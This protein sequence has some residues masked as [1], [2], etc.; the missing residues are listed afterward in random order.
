M[1]G[2]SV[3]P[4]GAWLSAVG[5]LR[6]LSRADPAAALHW[7]DATP[8]LS[9]ARTAPLR[10][11]ADRVPITPVI[12]PWQSGGGWGAKDKRS[13]DRLATLRSSVI[14]ESS[15]LNPLRRAI[16]AADAVIARH[17]SL[18][19]DELARILRNHLPDEALPWLDVAV[20][21]RSEPG[22]PGTLTVAWAPL[23]GTGGN[24]GRWDL[25][26]NYHAAI[27]ALALDEEPHPDISA[28]VRRAERRRGVLDDL[29][30]GT[31]YEPLAELSSGPYWP[32]ATVSG[33]ANPWA[34]ILTAEGLCAFGDQRMPEYGQRTQGWTASAGPEMGEEHAWG[35]AWLPMW[36]EPMTVP[37]VR[38]ILAGPWP[39]WRGRPAVRPADMYAALRARGWPPGV[40]GFARYGLAR[41][42]G[43]S[44]VA[45]P[46]DM[47]TPE[48]I[49]P[50]APLD[51]GLAAA[52]AGVAER[53]WT[54][55]VARKQ[56]PP[57]DAR[58]LRSGRPG[59]LPS[60]VDAWRAMRPGQGTRNDLS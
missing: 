5:A 51:A 13:A 21:L 31:E 3:G 28:S 20:P 38:V 48:R 59:W 8:V 43:R 11:I 26:A 27:L 4:M 10:D 42:H 22:A 23:A 56:A 32:A 16:E 29:L 12:T 44:H 49:P 50:E 39:R 30:N 52:R 41:R 36:G 58:D 9:S 54:A 33:L 57:P 19:K 24:D 40:T 55:Y 37:E 47:I 1:L 35:E 45:V 18:G 25:S 7:E 60:T 46:L 34:L 15:R 14:R 6:M 53:T 2:L 17:G